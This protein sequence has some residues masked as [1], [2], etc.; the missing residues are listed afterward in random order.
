[1]GDYDNDGWPDLYVTYYGFNV[2]YRN[3]GDGTFEERARQAGVAGEKPHWGAGCTFVDYDRDGYL[4][5]FVANYV[6]YENLEV[7]AGRPTCDWRGMPVVCG[8]LG[9]PRDSNLLYHN[10][11]DGT[12]SNV[13]QSSEI[14]A[15]EAHYCFQPVSVDLDGDG[16]PDIYVACDSTRNIL[17]R[18]N[19]D[20]T[21]TDVGL[22]SGVAL[23][24]DGNAQASMGVAVGDFNGDGRQDLLVT[25]FSE[26][27]PTLYKNLGDWLFA[28]VTLPAQLGRYRRYLGWGAIF[29]DFDNDGWEDLFMANGHVYPAIDKYNLGSYKQSR[30]LYRNRG[31]ETFADLSFQGGPAIVD[32]N[33]SRG[34]A[35]EDFNRDGK[36]DLVI[37]NLDG[38]PSLL[39]NQGKGANWIIL[40]LIGERSNRS[41]IGARTTIEAGGRKQMREVRGASSFYSSN[42]LRLHFG[43]GSAKRVDKLRIV[44]PSGQTTEFSSLEVNRTYITRESGAISSQ[45]GNQGV[46]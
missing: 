41:A 28:D 43:L 35:C 4:D 6:G 40:G 45:P 34:A 17:Y 22:N 32:R 23:N 27:T 26:D 2:L 29:F 12:F 24:A 25:N 14:V 46:H 3:R 36:M 7:V 20:G 1:V 21:F 39:I 5:L 10:N 19:K 18:N 31:D 11:R 44:W 16:W 8:P 33:A 15:T 13:S 9:L 42:G 38:P 30:L 37:T